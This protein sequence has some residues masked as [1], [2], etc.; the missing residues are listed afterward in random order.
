MGSLAG[1]VIPSA[2]LAIW[3]LSWLTLSF[4]L[5]LRVTKLGVRKTTHTAAVLQRRS[6]IPLFCG[7]TRFPVEPLL[8]ILMACAGV[9]METF[10]KS[11]Y[12]GR[13]GYYVEVWTLYNE[14][15]EFVH[16]LAKLQHTT[17]HCCIIISGIIDVLALYVQLPKQ[18][19]QVFLT[20]VFL[21]TGF[22]MYFHPDS[23]RKPVDLL[24]HNLYAYSNVASAIFSGLRMLSASN[25]WINTGFSLSLILQATW[26]TQV[27]YV[28][29]GPTRWNLEYEANE[30]FLVTCFVWHVM[31][32]LVCALIYYVVLLV[33]ASKK[34]GS[35]RIA[36]E[37]ERNQLLSDEGVIL[38]SI[39]NAHTDVKETRT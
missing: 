9:F 28:G 15:G 20:V 26:L 18:T 31:A 4:W 14:E 37:A 21:S 2:F 36:D 3:G 25:L 24:T 17:I 38:E 34:C 33:Y 22:I 12:N 13:S 5:H 19:P 35:D 8:K 1:H 27:G 11:R 30:V 16:N 10:F 6:Y 23:G 39:S 7:C 32:I 29:T